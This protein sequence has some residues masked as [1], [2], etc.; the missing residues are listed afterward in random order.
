M[1]FRSRNIFFE[2]EA[3]GAAAMERIA[4]AFDG[5]KVSSS[6]T[7]S[8]ILQGSNTHNL[9]V[10]PRGETHPLI[11]AGDLDVMLFQSIW[12][13]PGK[14]LMNI[15]AYDNA[16]LERAKTAVGN[17]GETSPLITHSVGR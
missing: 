10:N 7:P 15:R 4:R 13:E 8:K 5:Q 9:I 2:T 12:G 14:W 6:A 17:A 1:D 11:P 16:D 3:D